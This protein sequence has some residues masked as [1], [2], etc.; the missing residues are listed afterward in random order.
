MP[1]SI[2]SRAH[3]IKIRIA[4]PAVENAANLTLMEFVA[5]TLGVV[6]AAPATPHD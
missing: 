6:T 2:T 4:A 1:F 5:E 3:V